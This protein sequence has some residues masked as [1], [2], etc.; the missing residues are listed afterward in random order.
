MKLCNS[1][2]NAVQKRWLENM[3]VIE[4]VGKEPVSSAQAQLA[5]LKQQE[6]LLKRQKANADVKRKR[7]QLLKAQQQQLAIGKSA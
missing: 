6:K 4:I 7:E 1:L 3:L 5:S 2:A